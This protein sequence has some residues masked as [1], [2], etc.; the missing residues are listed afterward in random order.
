MGCIQIRFFSQSKPRK[1]DADMLEFSEVNRSCFLSAR[2]QQA[3]HDSS[4][5]GAYGVRRWEVKEEIVKMKLYFHCQKWFV[6]YL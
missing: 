6:I 5:E 4:P 3:N 1:K 2:R